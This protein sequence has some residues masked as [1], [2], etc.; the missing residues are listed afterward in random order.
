MLYCVCTGKRV[1]KGIISGS[2]RSSKFNQTT[3]LQMKSMLEHVIL[4]AGK[5][6]SYVFYI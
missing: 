4:V 5:K 3:I 6:F 1:V 2:V